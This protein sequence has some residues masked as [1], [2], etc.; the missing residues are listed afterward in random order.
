M[1]CPETA[2]TVLQVVKGGIE[3]LVGAGR[4]RVGC[5]RKV[6]NVSLH[7]RGRGGTKL[8]V[9]PERIVSSAA[10][11]VLQKLLS[12]STHLVAAMHGVTPYHVCNPTI[13]SLRVL[14]G[15]R[16]GSWGSSDVAPP[17][18][19]N[20]RPAVQGMDLNFQK[21][22]FC[23]NCSEE[24]NSPPSPKSNFT[25]YHI[26]IDV[27]NSCQKPGRNKE[28]SAVSCFFYLF[29]LHPDML[30]FLSKNRYDAPVAAI[31]TA[32]VSQMRS[33]AAAPAFQSEALEAPSLL[34]PAVM[35]VFQLPRP[36]PLPDPGSPY[37][38]STLAAIGASPAR[39][40]SPRATTPA[41]CAL[42][43]NEEKS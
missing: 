3:A 43:D 38:T 19:V 29:P 34:R 2:G 4:R 22:L 6:D 13:L 32:V 12:S 26:S 7:R 25:R 24:H 35:M 5:R 16:G 9:A 42:Q 37:E 31:K 15:L 23:T 27:K 21:G 8:L 14:P 20:W 33:L 39:H 40:V 17:R 41:D 11:A 28:Q 30:D 36:I 10:Y 18:W 1:K